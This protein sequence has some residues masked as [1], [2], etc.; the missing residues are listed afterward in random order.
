MHANEPYVNVNQEKD[1]N[2]TLKRT[3]DAGKEEGGENSNHD[4]VLGSDIDWAR[5]LATRLNEK[6]R[7]DFYLNVVRRYSISTIKQTLAECFQT[8]DRS[9]R[10]SRAALFMYLLKHHAT[11][12]DNHSGS[13]TEPQDHGF[14][15]CG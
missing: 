4:D 13:G 10:K 12:R 11:R 14:R 6:H 7:I 3:L 2:V 15:H 8:P 9:I 5:Y 1:Q